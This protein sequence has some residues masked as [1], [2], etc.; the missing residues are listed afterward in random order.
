[1]H[2]IRVGMMEMRGIRVGMIEMQGIRMGM[3]LLGVGM[4]GIRAATKEIGVG[5]EDIGV[6]MGVIGCGNEGN[7]GENLR[8][9]VEMMNKKCGEGLKKKEMSTFINI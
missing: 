1:M 4:L 8:I 7:K 9:G 2:R 3:P 6:G 5:I